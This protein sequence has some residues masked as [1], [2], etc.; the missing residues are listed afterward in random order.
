MGINWQKG[1]NRLWLFFSIV[2][3]VLILAYVTVI[4]GFSEGVWVAT[5]FFGITF[6]A[7]HIVFRAVLWIIKGF[8]SP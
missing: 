4:E 7:G 5:I 1:F 2:P 3:G 8:R 6:V